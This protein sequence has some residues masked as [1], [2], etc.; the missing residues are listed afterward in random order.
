VLPVMIVPE[1]FAYS[2]IL[3]VAIS[4][5]AT[6]YPVWRAARIRPNEVLKFG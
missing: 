6:L 5:L 3:S 1:I 4:I 2:M